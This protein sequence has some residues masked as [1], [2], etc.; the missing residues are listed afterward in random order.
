MLP[1]ML[2]QGEGHIAVTSS[3]VGKFGFP[4]RSSYAAS[5]HALQGYFETV[6]LE[7]YNKG[8]RTTVASPGRI[9][10]N[11]SV[12]AV[13]GDGKKYGVMDPGQASGMT[14]EKCAQRYIRAIER[15][16]WETYIGNS[17]ILMIWFKR[18][19]PALFRRL[20]MRIRST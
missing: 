15:D 12:N 19:L 9:R 16:Q 14:A 13:L 6:G 1:S 5:K 7:Y 10:T 4:L 3:M 11:I 8:L 2:Q 18:F 20:A 17:E